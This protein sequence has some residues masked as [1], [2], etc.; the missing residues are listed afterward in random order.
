MYDPAEMFYGLSFLKFIRGLQTAGKIKPAN[1]KIAVITGPITYSIRIAEAI[2]DA[3]KEH[4]YE[5]SLYETVQAPTSEWG[6]TLAK[7]RSDPPAFIAVTHF[8]PADQAQFMLQFMSNP[9]NSL[10]YMQYG[11]SIAAFRDIAG[12]ASEGVLYSTL[13][14]A[15]QDDIGKKFAKDYLARAGAKA[16]VNSGVQTYTALHLF[17]VAAALAG[18][19]GVPYEDAQNR[20]IAEQ[21]RA[22]IY[23]APCGTVRF[24]PATQS[25]FSYPSQTDDPS[26]GMP[27]LFS[28]IKNKAES[29]YIISPPPYSTTEFQLPRW[30]KS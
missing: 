24:D 22:L 27:H 2:R 3:A 5:I 23:R 12:D 4:G 17:A 16:S 13:I 18:G 9:T 6:P 10:V 19:V 7:L 26:L 28:Q 14:G 29:G 21:L 25:A 1:N 15:L 20:K 30:M 11:A 8:F